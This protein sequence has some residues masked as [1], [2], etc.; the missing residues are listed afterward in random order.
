MTKIIQLVELMDTVREYLS[1]FKEGITEWW[2]IGK[3]RKLLDDIL[4]GQFPSN[5][6]LPLGERIPVCRQAGR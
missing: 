6:P 4:W 2:N 5:F 3:F 1:C